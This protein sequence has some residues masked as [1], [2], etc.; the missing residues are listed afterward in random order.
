MTSPRGH[1]RTRWRTAL[2]VVLLGAIATLVT[3]GVADVLIERGAQRG[4]VTVQRCTHVDDRMH[5]S[6][7][8]CAGGFVADD[9]SFTIPSLTFFNDHTID[10][11]TRLAATVK[12]PD[13]TTASLVS[14]VPWRLAVTGGGA[15]LLLLIQLYLWRTRP[16]R[17]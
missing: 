13:A 2:S 8:S 15:L 5:G 9:D 3:I 10:P 17:A 1:A 14:E 11:G 12:G 16:P 6:T 4:Q 7:Y